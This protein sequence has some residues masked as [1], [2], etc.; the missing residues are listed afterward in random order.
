MIIKGGLQFTDDVWLVRSMWHAPGESGLLQVT[1]LDGSVIVPKFIGKLPVGKIRGA[2]DKKVIAVRV[3]RSNTTLATLDLL[4]LTS[5]PLTSKHVAP[6]HQNSVPVS[7]L[8]QNRNE[9]SFADL[10]DSPVFNQILAPNINS[11]SNTNNSNSQLPT[12][13]PRTEVEKVCNSICS[14]F[15]L[16][17]DQIAV[18]KRVSNWFVEDSDL[19][20]KK[21]DDIILVHGVFGCGK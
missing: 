7:L 1:G 14:T 3:C 15:N 16:N 12:K 13:L 21:S 5:T 8:S 6:L 10:R 20:S 19:H 17:P 9:L 4:R 2:I 18:M 11:V